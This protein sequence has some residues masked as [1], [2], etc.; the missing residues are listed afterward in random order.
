ML[1]I[2]QSHK[3]LNEISLGDNI[4]VYFSSFAFFTIILLHCDLLIA[5]IASSINVDSVRISNLESHISP[6]GVFKGLFDGISTL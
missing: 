6:T 2:T 1:S 5:I 3:I 4:F